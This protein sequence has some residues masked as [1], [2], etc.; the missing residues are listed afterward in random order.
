MAPAAAQTKRLAAPLRR[1]SPM[2]C[3]KL[4]TAVP[5]R[6]PLMSV[7]SPSVPIPRPTRSMDGGGTSAVRATAKKSPVTS[8]IVAMKGSSIA[9]TNATWNF[10]T[11]HANGRAASNQRASAT[12][13]K[14][15]CRALPCGNQPCHVPTDAIAYQTRP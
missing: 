9:S 5:P 15:T 10:G 6:T 11:P 12:A 2:F 7:P 8:S 4:D 1:S 13:E 3:E 14:S